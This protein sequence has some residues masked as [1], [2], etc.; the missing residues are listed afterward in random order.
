MT[1]YISGFKSRYVACK[2]S[3]SFWLIIYNSPPDF[4]TPNLIHKINFTWYICL[5]GIVQSINYLGVRFGRLAGFRKDARK[6]I[7]VALISLP[8]N[9]PR[10]QCIWIFSSSQMGCLQDN[11]LCTFI[12]LYIIDLIM[13]HMYVR[14]PVGKCRIDL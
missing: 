8:L 9:N 1:L 3:S 13:E 11:S 12:L 10:R 2:E 7:L 5:I 4:P 6:N 14:I